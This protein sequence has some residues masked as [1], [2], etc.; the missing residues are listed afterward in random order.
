MRK[1]RN[2]EETSQLNVRIRTETIQRARWFASRDTTQP[3]RIGET[4][5]YLLT[6]AM[7]DI[8]VPPVGEL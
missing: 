6:R 1:N 7:D 2:G 5:D 4:F 3:P 8:G